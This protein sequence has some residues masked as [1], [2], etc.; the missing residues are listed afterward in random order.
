[1]SNEHTTSTANDFDF[2]I[3]DWQVTHR[4][5]KSRLTGSDDW[6]TFS[7]HCSTRKILG[8]QGNFDDNCLDT[9]DGPYFASTI[10][11][12]HKQSGLWS[13]WWLDGR[14]PEQLDSPMKGCFKDGTGTFY[15]DEH[16]QGKPIKVRFLWTMPSAE[17]PRWEQAFST[18]EGKTWETNWIMDF[19][20]R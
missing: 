11:T 14:M 5:L 18:D 20:R 16:Y 13:I 17:Q 7:G 2:F 1:M 3:G 4:K 12:F 9:P 6:E 10:R 19:T 8:G 15:A